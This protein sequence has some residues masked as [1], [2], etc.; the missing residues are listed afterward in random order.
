[1]SRTQGEP[2]LR[3]QCSNPLC[4]FSPKSRKEWGAALAARDETC[5]S[6]PEL[7][8]MLPHHT[9]PHEL[10]NNPR[11]LCMASSDIEAVIDIYSKRGNPGDYA[12]IFKKKN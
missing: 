9:T 2:K 1:M 12:Y 4:D 6:T 10:M 8:Y 3:D 7:P 11:T 5:R